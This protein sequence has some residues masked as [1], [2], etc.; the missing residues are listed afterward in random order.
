VSVLA[1]CGFD[2]AASQIL[3]DHNLIENEEQFE[4]FVEQS[5][6]MLK[7]RGYWDDNRETNIASGLESMMR[8]LVQ[9]SNKVRFVNEYHILITHLINNKYSLIQQIA[10]QSH[11]FTF[12]PHSEGYQPIIENQLGLKDENASLLDELQTIEISEEVF[13]EFH[14]LDEAVL[15]SMISDEKL[16]ISLRT[17]LKDFKRNEQKLDNIS[18]LNSNYVK[19]ETTVDQVVFLLPSD[20]FVWHLDYEQVNQDKIFIVPVPNSLYVSKLQETLDSHFK[21]TSAIKL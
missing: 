1:L 9:S 14:T 19:D 16:N 5:E 18:F 2:Q 12:Y 15:H 4:R 20:G 3:N 6:Q 21:L 11:S 8:L 13:N 7:L 17:F 10:D